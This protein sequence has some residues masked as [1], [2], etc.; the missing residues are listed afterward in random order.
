MSNFRGQKSF[1]HHLPADVRAWLISEIEKQTNTYAELVQKLA[2]RGFKISG[3]SLG[4]F[5]KIITD[6]IK[7]AGATNYD[8]SKRLKN[9][10]FSK[11][12]LEYGLISLQRDILIAEFSTLLATDEETQKEPIKPAQQTKGKKPWTP[13]FKE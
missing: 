10:D 3:S 4:R 2:E 8:L 7:F 9:P 1:I 11:K 5:G 6:R 13:I 12:V